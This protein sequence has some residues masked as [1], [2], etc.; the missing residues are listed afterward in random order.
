MKPPR[1]SR[2][3]IGAWDRLVGPGA[4]PAENAATLAGSLVGSALGWRSTERTAPRR[5]AAAFLC[6]D[7]VGGACA[8]NTRTTR[9]WYHRPGT[10]RADRFRFTAVHVHPF[11]GVWLWGIP[12]SYA[13]VTY[14]Y[15]LV[16]TALVSALPPR[17]QRVAG[18]A[19]TAVGAGIG[20]IRT[21]T[22]HQPR[23]LLAAYYAKLI[24]GHAVAPPSPREG[25]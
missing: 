6:A 23:W 22:G 10:T 4:S 19:L 2:H 17:Y 15:A 18:W 9:A 16:G 12:L 14:T 13:A 21:S 20:A 11:V 24:A 5:I 7:L 3:A 25:T 1:Q 8:N